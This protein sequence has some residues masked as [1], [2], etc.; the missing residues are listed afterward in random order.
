MGRPAT[1]LE[2]VLRDGRRHALR[3][4]TMAHGS[5]ETKALR[6]GY[7]AAGSSELARVHSMRAW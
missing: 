2:L 1:M 5:T 7:I 3:T 6:A 4:A